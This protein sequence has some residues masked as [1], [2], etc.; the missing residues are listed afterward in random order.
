MPRGAERKAGGMGL[1]PGMGSDP[2][3]RLL[4]TYPGAWAGPRG[5]RQPSP[6]RFNG[7]DPVLRAGGV[8]LAWAG[9][10]S[11]EHVPQ[12][13]AGAG[14]EHSRPS[15]AQGWSPGSARG[16]REGERDHKRVAS[17]S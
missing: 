1:H 11:Q 16:W 2:V 12:A 6:G 14:S 13:G 9:T 17:S 8:L 10:G 7:R 3:Y 4:Q 5:Q 15:S